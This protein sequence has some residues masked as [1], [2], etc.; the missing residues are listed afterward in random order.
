MSARLEATPSEDM[1]PLVPQAHMPPPMPATHPLERAHRYVHAPSTPTT[2]CS[3]I[4]AQ[5]RSSINSSKQS[6]VLCRCELSNAIACRYASDWWKVRG[7][8]QASMLRT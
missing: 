5:V 7:V 4:T 1:A 8:L 2:P 3:T 6:E